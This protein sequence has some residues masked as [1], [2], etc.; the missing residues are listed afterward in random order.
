MQLLDPANWR[1]VRKFF[2]PDRPGRLVG[3]HTFQTGNGACFVDRW[4]DPRAVVARSGGHCSL[5]GDPSALTPE[6]LAGHVSG[7][8]DAPPEFVPLIEKA[9]PDVLVWER[10]IFELPKAPA[11]A[12]NGSAVRRLGP[13]DVHR[14]W[15]L[16][17]EIDWIHNPWGGPYGLACSGYA[18]GGFDGDRLVSVAASFF[19]G[20]RYEDVGVVTDAAFRGRGVNPA[21]ATKLCQDIR[22]R[23]R[24]PSWSTSPDNT[25]SIRVAQK[26]GFEFVRPDRL[27]VVGQEIPEP[28]S[29]GESG[30]S[31]SEGEKR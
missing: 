17:P 4:P 18:W 1:L 11:P 22:S 30:E 13:G 14:V 5:S 19:V 28:A 2:L 20:Q 24:T 25:A 10:R 7:M 16:A 27:Y 21:C 31:A 3:L 12:G 29:V 8:I 15:G 26:L 6:D 23:R 9:F